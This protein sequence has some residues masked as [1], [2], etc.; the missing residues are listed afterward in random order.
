MFQSF[1][2]SAQRVLER[3]D[4]LARR[5][6]GALVE[7]LDLLAALVLESDSQASELLAEFGVETARLWA[8]LSTPA[9]EALEGT[10]SAF[11]FELSSGEPPLEPLSLSIRLRAVLNEAALSARGLNRRREVGTE[12]LLAGL[13]AS[14][15][16]AADLLREAGLEYQALFERLVQTTTGDS[17]PLPPAAEIPPLDLAEPGGGVD[18]GR[19]LDAS[20]NRVRE[21]LRVVEDYVRF[22]LDDPGLTRRL[23][24]VR[25]RFAE[26][27]RGLDANL[28]LDS[29]DTT[30]DVGTHIMTRSEQ[31]RENPA[32]YSRP[33]SSELPRHSGR[34]RSTANW[35]TSGWPAVSRCCATTSIRSR[36]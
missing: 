35:L 11:E 10:G 16:E 3:A 32:P 12:H 8:A 27:E 4:L 2:A 7:P 9:W 20:A 25:H 28:L 31:L 30:E 29:R 18:L 22:V 14:S 21:G 17:G 13:L 15:G 23:K 1:T 33:T 6:H 5:R 36:S 34:S 24:E 26:A 19:I